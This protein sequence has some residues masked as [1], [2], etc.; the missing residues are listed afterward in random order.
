[1]AK[2]IKST[3]T[4]EITPTKGGKMTGSTTLTE[5]SSGQQ[6]G[7]SVLAGTLAGAV[8]LGVTAPK[9]VFIQNTD[10]INYVE[11]DNVSGMTGWPQK[12]VPGAGILLRPPNGTLYARAHNDPVEIWVVTG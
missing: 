2:E 3:A 11:V 6:Y 4:V 8:A 1:M 7:F 12:I 9:V 5:D 10:P